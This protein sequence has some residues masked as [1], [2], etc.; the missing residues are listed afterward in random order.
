MGVWVALSLSLVVRGPCWADVAPLLF[1]YANEVEPASE[2]SYNVLELQPTSKTVD[3]L[4]KLGE[5]PVFVRL[6]SA[7]TRDRDTVRLG[8]WVI[9]RQA[10]ATPYAGRVEE[11]IECGR[12]GAALSH[13]RLWCSQLKEVH[14]EMDGTV[15]AHTACSEDGVLVRF[16]CMHIEVVVRS[17]LAV[18]SKDIF[19]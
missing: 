9:L 4:V 17:V 16:E 5:Q 13:V 6:L 12:H 3:A 15:W 7:V 1:R 19:V 11:I 2:M 8:D 18:Q 10:E 14:E